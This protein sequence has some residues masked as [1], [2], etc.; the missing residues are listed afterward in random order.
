MMQLDEQPYQIKKELT[1]LPMNRRG[2]K[3]DR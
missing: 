3:I 1:K 2:R